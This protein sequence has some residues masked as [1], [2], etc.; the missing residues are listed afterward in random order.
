MKAYI[1]AI[2]YHL[3]AGRLDN[4]SLAALH[5]DWPPEKI[6]AKTGFVSRAVAA[7]GECSSDLAVAAAR[8]LFASAGI[9][10]GEIDFLLLCTQTP[11]YL[12]PTT[13]CL[14]QHRLGLPTTCGALDFNLG[15][16]GFVYG[17]SLAK[18]LIETGQARHVLLITAETYTHLLHEGDK[19]V[20]AL[21]GDGAAATLVSGRPAESDLIG[22]F[23]FGTDGAGAPNL[24]VPA[25]GLR[26]PALPDA[27]VIEDTGGNRRTENNLFMNGPE[28]FNF[29]LKVVPLSV[30]SLLAKANLTPDEIDLWVV[31][32]ANRFMLDHLR[33]KLGI[34]P[35]KFPFLLSECGN[36]VSSTI[37]IALRMLQTQGR[38]PPGGRLG[39]LG[40]GVGYS[41]AGVTVRW[42]ESGATS[43]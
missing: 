42:P 12:L 18:G 33:R 40:F 29:T 20:R 7:P 35:E 16:S 8:N 15:C 25:G 9:N 3:P 37:P 22:P 2:D 10:P 1:R 39:L 30:S 4:T 24:I 28:I 27:R 6:E 31:H 38:M 11:D 17:L 21:F 34:S 14:V 32:Q 41:W 26:K 36:T 43:A 5:P 23:V 19:S 13:A